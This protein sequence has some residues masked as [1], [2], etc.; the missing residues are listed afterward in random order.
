VTARGNKGQGAGQRWRK[1]HCGSRVEREGRK[2][3][4]RMGNDRE[5]KEKDKEQDRLSKKGSGTR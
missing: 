3:R 1:K 2:A 4:R 5:G